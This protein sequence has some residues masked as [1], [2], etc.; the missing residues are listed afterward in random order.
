MYF[1]VH[2]IKKM[3]GH[4]V[5]VS[6]LFNFAA[7]GENTVVCFAF[8]VNKTNEGNINLDSPA[9]ADRGVRR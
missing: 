4:A 2:P 8:A 1:L 6:F 9:G 7:E 3:F 5:F